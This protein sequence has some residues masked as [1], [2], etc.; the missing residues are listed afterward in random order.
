MKRESNQDFAIC[1]DYMRNLCARGDTCKYKHPDKKYVFCH[2]YQKGKCT[3]DDCIFIHCSRDD[4]QHY[5]Q[6]GELPPHLAGLPQVNLSTVCKDYTRGECRR[7]NCKFRHPSREE[8]VE[9]DRQSADPPFV[10]RMRYE[11]EVFIERPP[12]PWTVHDENEMLKKTVANLKKQVSDLQATNEFLLEQNAQM[13]MKDKVSAGL[14]TVPTVTLTNAA[15]IQTPQVNGTAIR[16]VT[17]GV[18]T[19]PVSIAAVAGI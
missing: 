3:R 5:K 7:I 1:R 13:R 14:V 4:E 12:S 10:K 15:Q 2:D 6:F 19:V 8:R 18:A 17:A 9:R 11:T 16:A